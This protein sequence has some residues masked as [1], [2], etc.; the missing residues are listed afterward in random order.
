MA[1]THNHRS[2]TQR[3]L[4]GEVESLDLK[5]LGELVRQRR[6]TLSLRQAAEDVGISFSTLTRVEGGSQPDLTSF[7]K[8]C[9]WLGE[10]PSKFFT[11]VARRDL[12]PLEEAISHLHQDPRLTPEA[13]S[14]IAAMLQQMHGVLA[15]GGSSPER[16]LVACHLR[17]ASAMRPGVPHRLSALL[18]DV[19]AGLE[20]MAE[21]GEL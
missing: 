20:R 19:H 13:A 8:I 17:A 14:S 6:G 12:D 10:P 7:V 15:R 3:E 11:A 5:A 4:A 18:T 9:A 16:P 21:A 1:A 2:N